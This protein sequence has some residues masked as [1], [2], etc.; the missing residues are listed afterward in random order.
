MVDAS[1]RLRKLVCGLPAVRNETSNDEIDS[2][3]FLS[4]ARKGGVRNNHPTIRINDALML[5]CL[6]KLN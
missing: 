5:S 1:Y 3:T 2:R 4:A 6:S